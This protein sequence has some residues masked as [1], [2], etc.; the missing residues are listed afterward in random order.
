MIKSTTN[1]ISPSKSKFCPSKI[2]IKLQSSLLLSVANLNS[3]LSNSIVH[4]VLAPQAFVHQNSIAIGIIELKLPSTKL[5]E[6]GVRI[7]S[8]AWQM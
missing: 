6:F 7:T 2:L 8:L 5:K 3:V 1:S 4:G